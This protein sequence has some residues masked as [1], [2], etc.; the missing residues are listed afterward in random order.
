MNSLLPTAQ[1]FP[2][3]YI[4][5]TAAA[6]LSEQSSMQGIVASMMNTGH[7]GL[8]V[9]DAHRHTPPMLPEWEC[10]ILKKKKKVLAVNQLDLSLKNL[11][12]A[13]VFFFFNR[14]GRRRQEEAAAADALKFLCRSL[15][16]KV[17]CS[18]WSRCASCAPFLK[19]AAA[20]WESDEGK[21]SSAACNYRRSSLFAQRLCVNVTDGRDFS[22][23][24]FRV[25]ERAWWPEEEE[26]VSRFFTGGEEVVP[27]GKSIQ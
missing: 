13:R 24:C 5:P 2:R 27:K 10:E 19:V 15:K 20:G 26:E 4:F 11:H 22:L 9:H 16:L 14:C 18:S 7:T 17:K 3:G 12:H 1:W 6:G 21:L 25:V 23:N 8:Q